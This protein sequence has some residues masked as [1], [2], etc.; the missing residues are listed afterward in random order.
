MFDKKFDSVA[1]SLYRIHDRIERG[2]NRRKTTY[3]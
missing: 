1:E 2:N 3:D